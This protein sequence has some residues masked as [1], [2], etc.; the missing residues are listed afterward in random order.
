MRKALV[1]LL[2]LGA[3]TKSE[4]DTGVVDR[5]VYED[6][7]QYSGFEYVEGKG[8]GKH[9]LRSATQ[10]YRG[11]ASVEDVLGFYKK[12]M[13]QNGWTNAPETS[14]DAVT[15][16]FVKESEKCEIRVATDSQNKTVVTVV[17]SYKG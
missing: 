9:G 15:L 13:P 12:V 5:P 16:T 6:V 3:C 1:L 4:K 11:N 8:T 17:L 2:A 14:A 10:K 7:P